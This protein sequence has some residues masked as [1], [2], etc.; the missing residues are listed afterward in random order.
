MT[1][2]QVR[3]A[4]SS[5]EVFGQTSKGAF[6]VYAFYANLLRLLNLPQIEDKVEELEAF[7]NLYGQPTSPMKSSDCALLHREIFG[8]SEDSD[9]PADDPD[10][11]IAMILAEAQ[12]A[13]AEAEDA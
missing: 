7:W 8:N 13:E 4:L 6:D 5:D 9:A 3:F 12:E 10:S 1:S 11:A 2:Y